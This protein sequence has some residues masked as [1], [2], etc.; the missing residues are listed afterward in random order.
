MEQNVVVAG[1]VIVLLV[2][3]DCIVTVTTLLALAVVHA[4]DV[5]S[6]RK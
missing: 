2:M 4:P 5:I 3:A 1:A 6:L